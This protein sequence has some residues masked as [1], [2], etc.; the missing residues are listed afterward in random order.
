M[1]DVHTPEVRSFNMS[2]IKGTNTKPE[3]KVRKI[4]HNKGFRFRI[5]N[6]KLPGKPDLVFKK[7][8]AVI[9]VNGCFWH[10]HNCHFFK[11]PATR[12]EFWNQ[13]I[14]GNVK[15]DSENLKNLAELGYRIMIIWECSLKGKTRLDDQILGETIS[16]WLRSQNKF[17]EITGLV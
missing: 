6:R 8:K 17:C 4:L 5:N 11:L 10:K 15:K 13:K 3:I 16:T 12:T 1:A 9:F 2:A 14:N 7:Y